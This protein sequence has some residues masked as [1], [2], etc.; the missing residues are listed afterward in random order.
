[1]ETTTVAS[2]PYAAPSNGSAP[3][4]ISRKKLWIFIPLASLLLLAACALLAFHGYIAWMLA[5]PAIAPLSS[6]PLLAAG[7][8]YE[9]VRFASSDGASALEGWFIPAEGSDKA[10]IFSHGYGG[11]REELWVPFYSLAKELNKRSYNVLLFDYGYVQPNLS[12]TGGVRESRELQ[13]AIDFAKRK[14][15]KHTYVWG[16]SMGAGTA[17][18]TALHGKEIEAMILDSTF[19]LEPDTMFHNIKQRVDLPKFPSLPLIRLF[20]PVLNGTSMNQIPYQT[21]KETDYPMPIFFIHGQ[22]DAKAP[23]DVAQLI[24]A[25]QSSPKSS[26]WLLPEGRHELLYKANKKEYVKRTMAFLS[27]VEAETF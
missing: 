14:G 18:Q 20:F 12:V 15:M 22:K 3:I 16:F 25:S 19:L 26:L 6:N 5:R 11:N 4:T 9:D 27:G 1:M 2:V 7:L 17:L 10:V 24:H 21:V 23:Y 13:G 8:P